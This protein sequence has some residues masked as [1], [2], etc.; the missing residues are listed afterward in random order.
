MVGGLRF[1]TCDMKGTSLATSLPGV[2]AQGDGTLAWSC[3]RRAALAGIW[4]TSLAHRETREIR[5]SADRS[6]RRSWAWAIATITSPRART[7]S[8]G[9]RSRRVR[10]S[11]IRAKRNRS[12]WL[13]ALDRLT[14]ALARGAMPQEVKVSRAARQ[15]R[16]GRRSEEWRRWRSLLMGG[17]GAEGG[18]HDGL[19]LRSINRFL[20]Y[21]SSCLPWARS[22]FMSRVSCVQPPL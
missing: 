5:K 18:A 7:A 8:R 19:P 6:A 4:T 13:V 15:R 14:A 22:R 12:A 10:G 11:L 16:G 3:S 1:G 20:S 21:R 9:S 2:A 17:A